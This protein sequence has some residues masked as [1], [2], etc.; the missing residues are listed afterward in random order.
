MIDD[1]PPEY[2][3]LFVRVLAQFRLDPYGVH[4]IHH[5][6]RVLRNGREIAEHTPKVDTYL[7]DLFAL[8]HDSQRADEWSDPE[9]GP[10]AA[11]YLDDLI[12]EG[13]LPRPLDKYQRMELRA[14]ILDHAFGRVVSGDPAHGQQTIAAC[15]DADRLD[16][17]RL[18][19]R[20]SPQLLGTAYARRADVIQRV[21]DEAWNDADSAAIVGA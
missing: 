3:Q 2:D 18:G 6:W 10:R 1:F 9:H 13:H 5:W 17:A 14:A 7:T 4:G 8:L 19:I 20:P 21:W 12:A 11:K 15:W 16:L